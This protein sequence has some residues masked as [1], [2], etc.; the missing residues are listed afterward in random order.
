VY[1]KTTVNPLLRLEHYTLKRP[2][3]LLLVRASIGD[4]L[5]EVAVFKGFSSSLTRATAADP[6]VPVLPDTADIIQIDRLHSPYNPAAPQYIQ[7]G[8]TWEEIEPLLSQAGV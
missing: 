1:Q 5:D 7:Q 6:D 4:E 8:L 2:E 3:E